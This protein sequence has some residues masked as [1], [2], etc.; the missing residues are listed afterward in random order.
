MLSINR[1][2]KTTLGIP[3]SKT[4]LRSYREGYLKSVRGARVPFTMGRLQ[5]ALLAVTIFAVVGVHSV[6]AFAQA[7]APGGGVQI[8]EGN[9]VHAG[10]FTVPVNKSQILRLDVPFSDLRIGNP[11]IADVMPL[12]DRAIYVLGNAIGSTSLT[13][14]GPNRKL[15]AVADVNVTFDVQGLKARLFELLP[16]E[17]IKVHPAGGNLILTGHVSSGDV[18]EQAISIANNYA[19]GK[20]NN[21]LRV[22]D[23]QQVMLSI[24]FAEVERTAV[25]QLGVNLQAVLTN[26]ANVIFQSGLSAASGGFVPGLTQTVGTVIAGGTLTSGALSLSAFFDALENKG[27]LKTLAEPNLIALSGD[28]ADFLAGGE[29]PYRVINKDGE[30]GVEFKKFGVGLS[31]TPT[32][33]DS[34]R[35]NLV[36]APEVSKIDT[37]VDV[38]AGAALRVSRASTTVELGDGQSFAIAGLLQS[39]FDDSVSRVPGLGDVPIIGA[40][41]RSAQYRRKETELVILV[42]PRLVKPMSA[43]ETVLP[44]DKFIPPSDTDIFLMGKTEASRKAR[45][46][47]GQGQTKPAAGGLNGV[48]GH[49]IQ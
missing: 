22:R 4:W 18:A 13:I 33:L 31:F 23:R 29:F 48:S 46:T 3:P 47:S 44:S 15:I 39:D 30:V 7:P 25:K 42:T 26:G 41:F 8:R 10:E 6:P 43:N 16:K 21:M 38:A 35:I 36:V 20:V 17:K 40:L 9:G 27:A 5:A 34:S 1:L 12:S 45:M 49:I 11:K 19:G 24:R 14:Y 32:V 37:T 28:T 2:A